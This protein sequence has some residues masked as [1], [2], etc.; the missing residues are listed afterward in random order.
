MKY[1]CPQNELMRTRRI[2]PSPYWAL[3]DTSA[4]ELSRRKYFGLELIG[5]RGSW[6]LVE[7][8]RALPRSS[9]RGGVF[10]MTHSTI[11]R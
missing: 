1:W 6:T 9:E 11:L 2:S 4:S 10:L 8:W 7:R 5:T 3:A